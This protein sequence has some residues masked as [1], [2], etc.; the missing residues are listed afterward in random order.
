M[1]DADRM[2]EE[3]S[4]L[5]RTLL[6]AGV[7]ERPT[8]ESVRTAARVLGLVPRAAVLA[9]V[10][11]LLA[12]GLK[13]WARA[14]VLAPAMAVAGATAIFYG[15]VTGHAPVHAVAPSVSLAPVADAPPP[16]VVPVPDAPPVAVV[17]PS[18]S[19][20]PV[21]APSVRLAPARTEAAPHDPV[22]DVRRQVAWID[23]ARS[24][25]ESGDTTGALQ[26]LDGYDR[27]FPHGVLSEES[28][29][30]R[31]EAVFARGDVRGASGLARRFLV[32]HPHSVHAAKVRSLLDGAD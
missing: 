31:I 8:E 25:A 15:A 16:R 18:P 21:P 29:L 32:E 5:E 30:L 23:H 9:Y 3:G 6:R 10:A 1:S 4:E 11:S 2:L 17:V 22:V 27:T 19:S 20:A 26:A 13:S 28:A 7:S 24:L 14:T 12:K